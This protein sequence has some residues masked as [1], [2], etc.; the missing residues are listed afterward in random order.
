MSLD[1]AILQLKVSDENYVVFR[2]SETLEMNV[3]YN[4]KNS[5]A[6]NLITP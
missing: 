5:K 1:E 2:N 6:V 3:I 4:D